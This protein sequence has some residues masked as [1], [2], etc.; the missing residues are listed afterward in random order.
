[1]VLWWLWFQKW[2]DVLTHTWYVVNE[3]YYDTV[4]YRSIDSAIH[5]YLCICVYVYMYVYKYV[6][7]SMIRFIHVY[8]CIP[9]TQGFAN[10]PNVGRLRHTQPL[11]PC[12]GPWNNRRRQRRR[13]RVLFGSVAAGDDFVYICLLYNMCIYIYIYIYIH[14]FIWEDMYC[15]YCHHIWFL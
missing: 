3:F 11:E 14:R 10:A 5:D 13:F 8:I 7:Y 15:L 12:C 6:G 9:C 4:V 1:M 2:G